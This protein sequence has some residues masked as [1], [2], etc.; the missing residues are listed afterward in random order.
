VT[1]FD[2]RAFRN[3]L[4]N[5]GT[6]VTVVTTTTE[7]GD[8]LGMTASSFNSVSLDP[9]LVLWSIDNGANGVEAFSQAKHFC[10]NVLAADQSD[11]SNQFA[12]SG[13]DKFAGVAF[14]EGLGGS[15]KIKGAIAQFECSTW[16][17]YP[18]GDHKIIVGRVE[19]FST[20]EGEALMFVQGGY[21]KPTSLD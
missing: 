19:K 4:S 12:R 20:D 10:V 11:I 5:F 13:D 8:A 7:N 21:A 14:E 2:P 18:G 15:R 16:E 6:G 1:D 3:A 17:V 9:P